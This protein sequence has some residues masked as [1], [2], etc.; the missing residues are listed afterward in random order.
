MSDAE[1]YDEDEQYDADAPE[2]ALEEPPVEEIA[3]SSDNEDKDQEDNP[4]DNPDDSD[5]SDAEQPEGYHAAF[6]NTVETGPTLRKNIVVVDPTKRITSNSLS[7]YELT[8]LISIRA[9]QIENHNMVLTNVDGLDDAATMAMK[10]LTDGKC[11][12]VLRR[13]V[14]EYVVDGRITEYFEYWDP[15][16]M[17]FIGGR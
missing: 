9:T 8:Q 16:T 15:N 10:E 14:G 2:D 4:D 7:E 3:E 6:A 13:K 17:S 1:D 5:D 12:L 11:P